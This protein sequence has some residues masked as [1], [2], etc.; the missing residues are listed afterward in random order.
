MTTLKR[1]IPDY[2]RQKLRPIAAYWRQ[3]PFYRNRFISLGGRLE[4]YRIQGGLL[5]GFLDGTYENDLCQ[6]IEE[7]LKP[8]MICV[9]VGAHV[10]YIT[11]LMASCVGTQGRVFAFE[12]YPPNA[13]YLVKNTATNGMAERVIVENAAV[14]DGRDAV[15][16]LR[17]GRQRSPAE[18]KITRDHQGITVRALSLD[19]YFEGA[20]RLDFIKMDI[21]GAE[22]FA[23]IGM[24]HV[25]TILRP[26]L[27][28]EFHH[29]AAWAQRKVLLEADYLLYNVQ[30]KKWVTTSEGP[31][32]Y[33]I[34][35]VPSEKR[36]AVG[37]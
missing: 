21:E 26:L 22:E 35:A 36:A 13:A 7:Y 14:S 23:L 17:F 2:L 34:L 31:M 3:T 20:S 37:L 15:V 25:L 18:W 19:S 6:I 12:A 16:T 4:G 10:G 27:C 5:P 24:T 29:A 32:I 28:I 30:Q 1:L 11:L 33:H 9:D 8:G